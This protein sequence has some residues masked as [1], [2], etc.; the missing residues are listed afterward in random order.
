MIRR[1]HKEGYKRSRG[2]V[3]VWVAASMI[4]LFGAGALS[5]D[6][7]RLVVTRWR[8][9]TAAD[10]ASLAGA[11][12]LGEDLQSQEV[13]EINATQVAQ[14]VANDNKNGATYTVIFPKTTQCHVTGQ[15]VVP[16]TF[17]RILGVDASTVQAQAAAELSGV[18]GAKGLRPFGIE[19]PP[20]Q[21]FEFGVVYTLKLSSI[22]NKD[23]KDKDES[24]YPYHGNFHI[25]AFTGEEVGAAD[26]LDKIINGY[27]G[28]VKI[29]DSVLT[30][31]GNITGK[32]REGINTI[33]SWDNHSWEWYMSNLNDL[34]NSPRIITLPIVVGYEDASGRSYVTVVGFASFYVEELDNNSQVKGR[35]VKRVIPGSSGGGSTTYGSYS[36]HMVQ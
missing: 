29:G 32:T 35:F 17:A 5:L 22:D 30:Q 31:P 7:G 15:E 19:E 28:E 1:N 8:L 24:Q 33:I 23:K 12:E 27:D 21:S 25:L 26:Y 36:V 18:S 4:V 3:L 20:G 10:A 2:A 13:R 16:M 9:Q 34:Y 14:A 6:Y 11:W